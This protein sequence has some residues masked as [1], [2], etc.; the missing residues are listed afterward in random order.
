M[1][2]VGAGVAPVCSQQSP[3]ISAD[4]AAAP[5]RARICAWQMRDATHDHA[6]TSTFAPRGRRRVLGNSPALVDASFWATREFPAGSASGQTRSR[7]PTGWLSIGL[8]THVW[9]WLTFGL[10]PV[11]HR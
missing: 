5:R 9:V 2:L 10:Q 4:I 7:C 11:G 1:R 3:N 8:P 6:V